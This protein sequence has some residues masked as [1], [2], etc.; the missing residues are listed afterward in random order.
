V[1]KRNDGDW[2]LNGN[3]RTNLSRYTVGFADLAWES[4]VGLGGGMEEQTDMA[5]HAREK[6]LESDGV[7]K[8]DGEREGGEQ[9]SRVPMFPK[10]WQVGRYLQAYADMFLPNGVVRLNTKVLGVHRIE[11][12]RGTK[13]RVE[14]EDTRSK[15]SAER[16]YGIYDYLVVASGFFSK[17][18]PLNCTLERAA[19]QAHPTAVNIIHSSR[20]RK[21]EDFILTQPKG[22]GSLL[23]IGGSMS[24]SEAAASLA[25]QLSSAK[26]SPSTPGFEKLKV[27]QIVSRPFYALP[28]MVPA[29]DQDDAH[30][31]T[32]VP[33]DLCLYDLSRRAAAP[34]IPMSGRMPPQKAQSAHKFIRSLIGSD[35]ADLGA[36]ALVSTSTDAP[37]YV[38]ISENYSEFV[39]SGE[40]VPLA[41]RVIILREQEAMDNGGQGGGPRLLTAFVMHGATK[42]KVNNVAGV[43][44]ATGYSPSEALTFLPAGVREVLNY[45]SDSQRLP[46]LLEHHQTGSA[47]IPN[48]AFIGFYEGP[49]WGVME[50]QARLIAR[51]WSADVPS[52]KASALT[53]HQEKEKLRDLRD[54][55][56]GKETDVP[57]YWMGD[58]VGIMENLAHDL[59]ITR[60]DHGWTQRAGPVIPARY[61]ASTCD[62]IEGR[63]TVADVQRTLREAAHGRFVPRAAFRAIQ[64]TWKLH[65]RLHSL[66]PTFPSGVLDGTASFHPRAPSDGTFDAEFLYIESGV[67]AT[68]R[69][70]NMQ[71]SRRYVYRYREDTEQISVWFVKEDA[72]S[73]DYLYHNLAF[74]LEKPHCWTA[75]AEH[76]CIDDMYETTYDF[77]FRG[78]ALET[79]G[80]KHAVKGPKKDYVSDTWYKR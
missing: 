35:Q 17:S 10:A 5:E 40:I 44:Y 66:I 47:D 71:A 63:K 56:H 75:K 12:K 41:G 43:I 72:K 15:V 54:A 37:A 3:M 42:T 69:G 33:L 32:F 38:A 67:L 60:D 80:V 52:S 14:W 26:Y 79:F 30:A 8:P 53:S 64:G 34:I 2:V 46:F 16:G 22:T 78:I 36:E 7:G 31:G 39:R 13:W 45:D 24:G 28:P 51:Q 61:A 50:M 48:M 74:Q 49:Y 25:L 6:D 9:T 11:E 70:F 77:R 62:N 29:G 58:Y 20:F 59:K 23:V 65:R 73:V 27:M 4:V 68:D 19:S 57:Q 55:M 1:E 18:R 21:L 76:L